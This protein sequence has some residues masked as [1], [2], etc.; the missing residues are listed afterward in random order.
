[1]FYS[2][3]FLFFFFFCFLVW[4][5]KIPNMCECIAIP[6]KHNA[7]NAASIAATTKLNAA[8]LLQ[9]VGK[10]MKKNWKCVFFFFFLWCAALNLTNHT[11]GIHAFHFFKHISYYANSHISWNINENEKKTN[12]MKRKLK[13]KWNKYKTN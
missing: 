10:K 13:E 12:K 4:C 7:I 5:Y 3:F 8:H 6:L 11:N 9:F 2:L 1:M